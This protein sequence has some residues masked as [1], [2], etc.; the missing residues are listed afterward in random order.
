MSSVDR[1]AEITEQIIKLLFHCLFCASMYHTADT[2]ECRDDVQNNAWEHD[3][4][5][6]CLFLFISLLKKRS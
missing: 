1:T 6:V 4:N 2:I 3:L 5:F